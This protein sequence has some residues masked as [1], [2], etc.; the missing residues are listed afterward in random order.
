MQDWYHFQAFISSGAAVTPYVT[1]LR[2]GTGGKYRFQAYCFDADMTPYATALVDRTDCEHRLQASF[3]FDASVMPYG[4]GPCR[5]N[6]G[7]CIVHAF[8]SVDGFHTIDLQTR[9]L[10]TRISREPLLGFLLLDGVT[11]PCIQTDSV[12][13]GMSSIAFLFSSLLTL[14]NY[15]PY[16]LRVIIGKWRE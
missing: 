1:A 7:E 2:H 9:F 3:S 10:S 15:H 12:I 6:D 5:R 16:R 14:Q 13:E 11:L 8:S 4:K